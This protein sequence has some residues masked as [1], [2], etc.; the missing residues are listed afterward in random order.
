M[1]A[2]WILRIRSHVI[3]RRPPIG[4]DRSHFTRVGVGFQGACACV[5][6][7]PSAAG[8]PGCR[9]VAVVVSRPDL[10]LPYWTAIS[11]RGQPRRQVLSYRI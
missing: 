11:I 8:S 4:R 9:P 1:S 10:S 2:R 5:R 6:Q 7:P 3:V